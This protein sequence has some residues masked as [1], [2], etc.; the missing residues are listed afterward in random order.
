MLGMEMPC[1]KCGESHPPQCGCRYDLAMPRAV[2]RLME[3]LRALIALAEQKGDTEIEE[4]AMEAS[5][6]AM[7]AKIV[8]LK[9]RRAAQDSSEPP[10][11]S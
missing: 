6:H 1:H 9:R 2:D 11:P 3:D 4:L 7:R 5:N 10:S 8:V